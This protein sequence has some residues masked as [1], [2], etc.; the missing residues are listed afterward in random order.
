ML[1]HTRESSTVLRE[2][3]PTRNSMIFALPTDCSVATISSIG[4]I[5]KPRRNTTSGSAVVIVPVGP[6]DPIL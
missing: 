2:G 1:L 5:H 6:V 3:K 4:N